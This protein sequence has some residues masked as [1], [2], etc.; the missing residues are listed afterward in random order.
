LEKLK[1]RFAHAAG[2][3]IIEAAAGREAGEA[4]FYEEPEA[5]ET[6]S[7]VSGHSVAGASARMVRIVTLDDTLGQFGWDGADFLK[8]DAEGFDF[9]VLRGA[10]ALLAGRKIGVIQFDYNHPWAA[11]G[12]TLAAACR[13]LS[14][15]EYQV[16][17]L[18]KD[19]LY[20]LNYER[21]GEYFG[22]SDFVAVAP[23]KMPLLQKYARGEK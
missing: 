7:L 12:S 2:L 4:S 5:G 21:Y 23:D 18:Q 20:K 11:V 17:L 19:G 15:H 13:L 3:E 6:S 1:Q 22:Y 10:G 16:F 14:A 9:H 8:I